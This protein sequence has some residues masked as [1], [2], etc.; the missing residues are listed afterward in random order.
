M[1]LPASASCRLYLEVDGHS[2]I[3][4]PEG[5]ARP[6]PVWFD[7]DALAAAGRASPGGTGRAATVRF[8][9][10]G[11]T[12]ILRH[13]R[14]GGLVSRLVDDRYLRTGL[15][16]SRPWRELALLTRLH[17][18]GMPVPPPVAARISFENP[19][20][21]WYRGDL[22]TGYLDGIRTLAEALRAGQLGDL[23][24]PGIGATIARFHAVGVD[25]ADLNAH[26]VLIDDA[27][28]VYLIDFD[29]ARLRFRGR[30]RWGNLARLR[31]S[32]NKLQAAQ[33]Q[34]EFSEGAWQRL[35]GGYRS[36]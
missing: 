9:V 36:V 15:R 28:I 29:R 8:S 10:D 1:R 22:I 24:W 13:Y 3:V 31:R 14:R 7:P 16:R 35:L 5:H 12:M 25:H 27:G 30:W 6:D 32:L 23:D 33:P 4:W 18:G 17:A 34:I 19:L 11:D 21:P 20:L 26:N 2:V